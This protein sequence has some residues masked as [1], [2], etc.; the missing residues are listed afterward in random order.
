VGFPISSPHD[1]IANLFFSKES[2]PWRELLNKKHE[3]VK[4]KDGSIK[5]I[6]I[7]DTDVDPTLMVSFIR[8]S[9]YLPYMRTALAKLGSDKSFEKLDPRV[10]FISV[11]TSGVL[12]GKTW[13]FF[14]TQSA[15]DWGRV[16]AGEIL[17]G[18]REETF[19]NRG[20]YNRPIIEHA[21]GYDLDIKNSMPTFKSWVEAEEYLLTLKPKDYS[22]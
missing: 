10:Q 17:P 3:L 16:M 14:Y 6:I 22:K 9:R 19:L 12:D 11:A 7:L 20:A 13:N 21:F 18:L 15:P 8:S 5:G 4:G 2:S 1:Y